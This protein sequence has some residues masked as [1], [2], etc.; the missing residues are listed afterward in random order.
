M[1]RTITSPLC[2][3]LVLIHFFQTIFALT[4]TTFQPINGFD[5]ACT[6][7][8]NTPLTDCSASD[9]SG[10]GCSAKCIGF[11]DSL[12]TSLND[13]CAG[14]SAY[15]NTL[16]GLFFDGEGVQT[17]CPNTN[18][19]SSSGG[20]GSGSASSGGQNGA[21]SIQSV[22]GETG[23]STTSS[24]TSTTTSSSTPQA[25]A[26][27]STSSTPQAAATSSTTT[28]VPTTV[29]P[30]STTTSIAV[31]GTTITP[32]SSSDTSTH[33]SHTKSSTT[34]SSTSTSTSNGNGGGTPLDIG[35]SACHDVAVSPW[36]FALLSASA[37]L[38]WLL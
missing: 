35:S 18:G 38:A 17:L 26:T 7:T 4:L 20:G 12:T 27:T 9:F 5:L 34:S 14:T 22:V 25:A 6:N 24:S 2:T 30:E 32:E 10:G 23:I 16:I 21:Y 29:T 37:G 11:L 15:P 31:V 28:I 3:A 36:L 13:V 33:T 19:G 1:R 8:Y